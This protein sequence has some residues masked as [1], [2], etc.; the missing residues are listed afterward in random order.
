M[1]FQFALP[2]K[3]VLE[4]GNWCETLG[5]FTG[6]HFPEIN[7]NS[8]DMNHLKFDLTVSIKVRFIANDQSL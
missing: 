3:V 1:Y 4:D 6:V 2:G 8:H 7:L 5:L